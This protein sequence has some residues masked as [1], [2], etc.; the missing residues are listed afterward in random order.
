M[1]VTEVSRKTSRAASQPTK[2]LRV[3]TETN[4]QYSAAQKHVKKVGNYTDVKQAGIEHV[5]CNVLYVNIWPVK[6]GNAVMQ[7]K[8]FTACKIIV[9]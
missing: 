5:Q 4:Y 9:V 8:V 3:I 1:N 6:R 2:L 7:F